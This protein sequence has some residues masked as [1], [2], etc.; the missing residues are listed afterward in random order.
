MLAQNVQTQGISGMFSVY[1]G[2]QTAVT[3]GGGSFEEILQGTKN[4]SVKEQTTKEA[5]SAVAKEEPGTKK[6]ETETQAGKECRNEKASDTVNQPKKQEKPSEAS[7]NT[8]NPEYAEKVAALITQVLEIVKDV[9]ELTD[10]QMNH[11]L[12]E[13]GMTE[14]GLL[15]PEMLKDFY[16]KVQQEP[17]ASA[18][19]TDASLL[20]GFRQLNEAV[21]ERK[22]QSGIPEEVLSEQLLVM[23]T[24]NAAEEKFPLQ[25]NA[26]V[27]KQHETSAEK[28]ENVA[29]TET[30]SRTSSETKEVTLEFKTETE[31]GTDKAKTAAEPVKQ[32]ETDAMQS[33]QFLQNLQ[34]A[35]EQRVETIPEAENLAAQIREIADQ[36]L[37]KV[38]VVVSPETTSLEIQLTPEHLGKVHLTITEQ[39]GTLKARFFTE[40]ELSKEAIESNLVQFKETLNAQGLK[41]ES[42]EVMVSEFSFEK[43][44]QAGQN[45]QDGEKKGRRHFA[46]EEAEETI[47][48]PDRLTEHFMEEGESTVNYMV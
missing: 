40:N 9:L 25:N 45:E 27:S 22:E 17:D 26:A 20:E 3:Q 42:I 29:V 28:E 1:R 43:N 15:E 12:D 48:R 24:E 2:R 21:E 38:R 33:G 37:E 13:F 7:E 14:A 34:K 18:L 41:V 46:A 39:D 32:Q 8:E 5:D 6:T 19:L 10:E 31:S 35:V 11:L 44:N 30:E 47:I 4:V 16:L 36:L 23:E